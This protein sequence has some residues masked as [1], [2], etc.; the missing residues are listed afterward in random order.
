MKEI[1]KELKLSKLS[2]NTMQNIKAGDSCECGQ[3]SGED[4]TYQV[5]FASHQQVLAQIFGGGY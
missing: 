4:H 1:K 5:S 3:C 2:D